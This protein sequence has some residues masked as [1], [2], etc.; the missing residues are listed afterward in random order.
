MKLCTKCKISKSFDSFYPDRYK[1]I[2][3]SS[4]CRQCTTD[5][6]AAKTQANRDNYT[7]PTVTEKICS[8]CDRSKSF[9][10][11]ATDI[12]HVDGLSS[13]CL[14]C[15]KVSQASIRNERGHVYNET[16]REKYNSDEDYRKGRALMNRR[17]R[18]NNP[19]QVAINRKKYEANAYGVLSEIY[20]KEQI[21]N[22][23]QWICQICFEPVPQN[24]SY[25]DPLYPTIDHIIALSLGGPDIIV[26]IRLA[27]N[28]CNTSKRE[29]LLVKD[30]YIVEILSSDYD[31]SLDGVKWV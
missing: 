26:N 16:R 7:G 15:N 24:I 25:P 13:C 31:V 18:Q 6:L 4:H 19:E 17:W 9:V 23:D 14:G 1:K 28:R 27:H 10:E 11:F 3:Y 21:F 22:R 29:R 5:R 20:I 8:K 12:T 30:K 2:G